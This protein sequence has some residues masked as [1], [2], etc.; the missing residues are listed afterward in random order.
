MAHILAI[1]LLALLATASAQQQLPPQCDPVKVLTPYPIDFLGS[2]KF[3]KVGKMVHGHC[4]GH[5]HTVCTP[6][7]RSPA[8]AIKRSNIKQDVPEPPAPF[9]HPP[10]FPSL[11]Q[12]L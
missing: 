10:L 11:M 12:A 9:P 5:H 1:A 4:F 7:N 8:F 3:T 2:H 6:R